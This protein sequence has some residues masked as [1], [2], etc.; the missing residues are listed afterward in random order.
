VR[1]PR[2]LLAE[3][4]AL[5]LLARAATALLP[6]PL[7]L[8]L[9]VRVPE[10]AAAADSPIIAHICHAVS[11]I[12]HWPFRWAVC[13]PQALAAHWMLAR[14]AIP[15]QIQFGVRSCSGALSSHAWLV[16]N[17]R[18]ILGHRAGLTYQPVFEF[19]PQK[20]V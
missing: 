18:H 7:L 2:L 17:G 19:P 5:T 4:L 12:A 13:L 3:A 20:A 9:L 11:R 15:S 10:A 16:C 8:R 6:F 14:R 1:T